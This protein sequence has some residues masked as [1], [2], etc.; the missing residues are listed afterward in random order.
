MKNLILFPDSLTILFISSLFVVTAFAIG[1]FNKKVLSKKKVMWLILSAL[2]IS[3]STVVFSTKA[4]CGM[5]ICYFHGW[6][7]VLYISNFKPSFNILRAF[8]SPVYLLSNSIFYT[9]L[10][11]T[12]E[13]FIYSII[14]KIRKLY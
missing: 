4:Y 8:S 9:T 1:G 7:H 12:L 13:F 6:P 10:Y 14:R 11:T 2:I 3:I 5:S